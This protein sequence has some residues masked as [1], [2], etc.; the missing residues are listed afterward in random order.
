MSKHKHHSFKSRWPQHRDTWAR[1]W[2]TFRCAAHVSQ[3]SLAPSPGSSAAQM[4]KRR[5]NPRRN[6]AEEII[7]E[8]T[9]QGPH[10]LSHKGNILCSR[11]ILKSACRQFTTRYVAGC[12]VGDVTKLRK[13]LTVTSWESTIKKGMEYPSLSKSGLTGLLSGMKT[14]SVLR[15]N[16]FNPSSLPGGESNR[17]NKSSPS[18]YKCENTNKTTLTQQ[19]YTFTHF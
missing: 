10:I 7:C 3:F 19:T 11:L 15:F 14:D 1:L 9:D 16:K 12:L 8:E 2:L 6:K 4:H 18:K 17:A 13:G 5:R